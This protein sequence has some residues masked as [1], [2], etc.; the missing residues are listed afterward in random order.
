M[1]GL[2]FITFLAACGAG[3]ITAERLIP[4]YQGVETR[5]LQ[6]DLVQFEVVMTN[7][8]SVR[9]VED[10]AQCAAAGYTLIRGFGFARKV[11]TT[12][13]RSART[14][15]G[16]AVYLISATVPRGLSTIDAELAVETCNDKGIPTV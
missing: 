13:T 9:D 6:D 12:V 5:L 15:Q 1:K 2:V 16:D 3:N 7:A 4:D 14:W 10:Y 11:R 8:L